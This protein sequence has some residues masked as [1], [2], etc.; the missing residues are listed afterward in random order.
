M[1][2]ILRKKIVKYSLIFAL[3]LLLKHK[4]PLNGSVIESIITGQR[5]NRLT[6]AFAH[7]QE[8]L[9]DGS[10]VAEAVEVFCEEI[11]LS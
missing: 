11:R 4:L 6:Q 10:S 9:S 8:V 2:L 3:L 5:D 7:M 1:R